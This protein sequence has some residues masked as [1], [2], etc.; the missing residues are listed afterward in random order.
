MYKGAQ[1]IQEC[2][3]I[4]WCAGYTRVY[5]GAQGIQWCSVYTMVCRMMCSGKLLVISKLL[6]I[7]YTM[8]KI[9]TFLLSKYLEDISDQNENNETKSKGQEKREK[10]KRAIKRSKKNTI[11]DRLQ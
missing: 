10:M 2:A 11:K 9:K 8:F 6:V 5:N 1:S 3:C 7:G 4:Q